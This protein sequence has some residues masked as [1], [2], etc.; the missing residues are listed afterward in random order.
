M[1]SINPTLA[2]GS[3]TTVYLPG[4]IAFA[5]R[6]RIALS[7]AIV[8]ALAVSSLATSLKSRLTQPDPVPSGVRTVVEK[9][10]FD[11]L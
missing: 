7:T 8:A 3:K 2:A 6:D 9:S 1:R 10:T 5:S 4:S 11:D